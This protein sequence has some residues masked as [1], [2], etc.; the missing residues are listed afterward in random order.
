[1]KVKSD[2][3][4]VNEFWRAEPEALFRTKT[5]ALVFCTSEETLKR[6]RKRMVG[7]PYLK[8]GY[9]VLYRK[10]DVLKWLYENGLRD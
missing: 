2:E 3:E 4:K 8:F 5:I 7:I 1:M 6:D 10:G 9:T